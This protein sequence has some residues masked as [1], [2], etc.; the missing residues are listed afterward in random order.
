MKN[1]TKTKTP[2]QRI[3]TARKYLMSSLESNESYAGHVAYDFYF[4]TIDEV[5]FREKLDK[6]RWENTETCELL[7]ILSGE[8]ND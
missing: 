8:A 4:D 2:T 5:E 7:D 6:I 3:E 1:K